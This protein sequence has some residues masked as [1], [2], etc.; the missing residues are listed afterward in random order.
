M[1]KKVVMFGSNGFENTLVRHSNE[2]KTLGIFDD[3]IV[4]QQKDIS[5]FIENHRQFLLIL[6]GVLAVIYGNPM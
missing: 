2:F 6:K 5:E 3:I 4:L 1:V